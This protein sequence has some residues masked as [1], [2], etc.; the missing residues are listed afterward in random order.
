[1][2][3]N[4]VK[5]KRTNARDS[6]KTLGAHVSTSLSWKDEFEH[7]KQKMKNYIKTLMKADMKFYRVCFHF[8]TCMLTNV[9]LDVW[10]SVLIRNYAKNLKNMWIDYHKK[11]GIM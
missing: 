7:V 9:F 6:V 3:I 10:L 5:I 1:M 8:K 11:N 2:T 4:E